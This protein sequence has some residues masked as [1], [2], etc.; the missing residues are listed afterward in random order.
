M[1]CRRSRGFTLVELMVVVVIVTILSTLAVS[2]YHKFMIRARSTE[3]FAMFAEIR[4]KEESYRAEFTSYLSVSTS[5]TDFYPVLGSAGNEPTTKTWAP[6]NTN[7]TNLGVSPPRTQLYCGY[8]VVAGAAN[9]WGSATNT[10]TQTFLSGTAP[11]VN[12]WAAVA[13]CDNDG[14]AGSLNDGRNATF[15]TSSRTTSTLETNPTR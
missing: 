1:Q 13:M 10:V 14:V 2:A 15:V 5:D 12:W 8:A 4:A 7:W 11:T 9:S 6:T 3:V